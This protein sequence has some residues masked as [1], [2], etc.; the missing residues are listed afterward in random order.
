M[1][2]MD[3]EL[4]KEIR[5]TIEDIQECIII[6][7]GRFIRQEEILNMNVRELLTMINPNNIEFRVKHK[8][9]CDV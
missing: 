1:E 6:V 3:K 7:G 2:A 9:E 4:D 5:S 8:L